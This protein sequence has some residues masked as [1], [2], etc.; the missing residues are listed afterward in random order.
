LG[1]TGLGRILKTEGI[2]EQ[3]ENVRMEVR[4][5]GGNRTP[6]LRGGS[7]SY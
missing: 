2:S 6:K 1:E 5:G 4:G 3:A 7:M